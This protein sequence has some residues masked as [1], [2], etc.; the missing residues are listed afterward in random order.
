MLTSDIIAE[1]LTGRDAARWRPISRPRVQPRG[2]PA[3]P[4]RGRAPTWPAPASPSSRWPTT[5][6]P[7]P[8][9]APAPPTGTSRDMTTRYIVYRPAQM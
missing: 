8:P 4:A 5:A 6:S 2:R 7:P 3:P 1:G 9:P